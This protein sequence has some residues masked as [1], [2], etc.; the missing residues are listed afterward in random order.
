M[1]CIPTHPPSLPLPNS[2]KYNADGTYAD[3]LFPEGVELTRTTTR[4]SATVR[5]R[6]DNI[7]LSILCSTLLLLQTRGISFGGEKVDAFVCR[8]SQ[9][10]HNQPYYQRTEATSYKQSTSGAQC[11]SI[12][13]QREKHLWHAVFQYKQ[14]GS[15][16]FSNE[17]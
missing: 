10:K 7:Q 14:F 11:K 1:V 16:F 3:Q 15:L 17:R 4:A 8:F 9:Q 13:Q 2:T 5:T 6:G 12:Q